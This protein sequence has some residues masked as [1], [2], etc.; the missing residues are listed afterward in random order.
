LVIDQTPLF[1]ESMNPH[2]RTNISRQIPPTSSNGEVLRRVEPIRVDHKVSVVLVVLRRLAPVLGREELGKRPPFDRGDGGEI[3]PGRVRGD[4]DGVSL[5]S[6]VGGCSGSEGGEILV[7]FLGVGFGGLRS[8]GRVFGLARGGVGVG[9]GVE[10][11]RDGLKL[12]DGGSRGGWAG[13]D[14]RKKALADEPPLRECTDKGFYHRGREDQQDH[15][16]PWRCCR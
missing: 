2:D 1:Q 5:G 8:E 10:G 3:K 4:D 14:E 13:L 9:R 16:C 11:A 12:G 15:P 6:E 7:F